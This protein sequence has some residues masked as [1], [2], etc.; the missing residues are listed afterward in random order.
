[1]S[2]DVRASVSTAA[3]APQTA[4]SDSGFQNQLFEIGG[5][6]DFTRVMEQQASARREAQQARQQERERDREAADRLDSGKRLP[7]RHEQQAARNEQAAEQASRRQ[8]AAR[9]KARERADRV[10]AGAAADARAE[11]ADVQSQAVQNQAAQ[12]QAAQNQK[13]QCANDPQQDSQSPDASASNALSSE[14][15]DAAAAAQVAQDQTTQTL[16]DAAATAAAITSDAKAATD[17][18]ASTLQE[19]SDPAGAPGVAGASL[20]A[21]AT[22]SAAQSA[23]T[24]VQAAMLAL[25]AGQADAQA[26]MAAAA[27][28]TADGDGAQSASEPALL[29]GLAS[30]AVTDAMAAE[31]AIAEAALSADSLESALDAASASGTAGSPVQNG[32]DLAAEA[33]AALAAQN[34][35][36]ATADGAVPVTQSTQPGPQPAA[37]RTD[38]RMLPGESSPASTATDTASVDADALEKWQASE[39]TPAEKSVEARAEAGKSMPMNPERMPAFKEQLAALAQ[40]MEAGGK[41]ASAVA[42]ESKADTTGDVKGVAFTRTLEQLSGA[43]GESAKPLSTGIQTPLTSREWAGEMGQ[44][45]VM[46]VSSKIKSAEIHL[47]PKDLGPVEVRIRMHEDKAHVVFTSQVAQTREAL[48]QAMPRLREMLDQN[49]VTLGN[50]NVQDH[51]AQHSH[52][53]QQQ[54]SHGSGSQRD[55]L[56]VDDAGPV[57]VVKRDIGLVDFYA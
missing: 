29:E 52:Q 2:T 25:A 32:A 31:A 47:N 45:L 15:Q 1:M 56:A 28:G 10:E 38:M 9:D 6:T 19:M 22:Q 51:G 33:A 42:A 4:R 7:D 11:Q 43:R 26:A 24:A 8:M 13:F 53:R 5:D 50:A 14:A 48:E 41:A 39:Q 57:N 36:Q 34:P 18:A 35:L 40:Q 49:G 16:Q 17:S 37:K 23:M 54:D 44:R 21:G 12:D 55:T 46:M 27:Q 30:G 3:V 20:P